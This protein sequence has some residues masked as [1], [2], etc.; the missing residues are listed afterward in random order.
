MTLLFLSNEKIGHNKGGGMS[1]HLTGNAVFV[2]Q[3]TQTHKSSPPSNQLYHQL[4]SLI[5]ADM[6]SDDSKCT[7]SQADTLHL[8]FTCDLER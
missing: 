8:L 2:W 1:K 4:M 3:N 6:N 5:E 7:C